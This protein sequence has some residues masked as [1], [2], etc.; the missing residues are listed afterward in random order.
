MNVFLQRHATTVLVAMAT[1]VVTAGGPALAVAVAQAVNADTVDSF[2]AVGAGAS[3]SN[4]AGKLVATNGSTGRL[5]N[6]I[7]ATAPNSARLGGLRPS[8][9]SRANH[10]HDDRYLTES[11][12]TTDAHN[13]L[14]INAG[15]LD[16][17][18]STQLQ[19]SLTRTVIVSPAATP[20]ESGTALDDALAVIPTVGADAPTANNHW[21][22]YLEPGVYDLGS[23]GITMRSH[24]DIVGSGIDTTTLLCGCSGYDDTD[25]FAVHA[26]PGEAALRSLTVRNTGG[27]PQFAAALLVTEGVHQISDVKL[28]VTGTNRKFGIQILDGAVTAHHVIATVSG[29]GDTGYGLSVS[30]GTLTV[31][32]S[33][34]IGT[35]NS[36]IN[37][38]GTIRL[39]STM[40][41]G[42]ASGSMSCVGAYS[43][44]FVALNA[45]CGP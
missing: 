21:M 34:A 4:R 24:V 29:G 6:D 26:G 30:G 2:H 15:S 42:P 40:L 11:D 18:D 1:A 7:I 33:Q 45:A 9:F 5:P 38:G 44:A 31:T 27:L 17:L 22:I 39:A 8:A 12:H 41:S 37:E 3:R 23:D 35:T 36:V 13:V 25:E 19:R 14:E 20:A 43:A 16:G 28:E 10:N 32:D